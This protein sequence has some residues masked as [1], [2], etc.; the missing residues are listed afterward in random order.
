MKTSEMHQT[1][2]RIISQRLE[3]NAN[4]LEKMFS[5][6]NGKI[7]TRFLIIDDLLPTG[8]A[9][10]IY[11]SFPNKEQ[12]RRLSSFR[13]RKFTYKQL[14]NTSELLKEITFAIQSP[15][16]VARVEKITKIPHQ[17][18]D[19]SLYAG[20]ISMMT[21]GDFLNPHIDNSHDSDRHR[22]RTLNL[23][24]YVTPD[25]KPE[26]GGNLELWDENVREAET[27]PSKFNRFVI[28]ETNRNSWHSV[29]PVTHDGQRC[30]VSNYYF[31]EKSPEGEEYFHVT[32]FS[33]RPEQ[34][35][36]RA[37]ARFD[38]FVRNGLRFIFR[39]GMGKS[40]IYKSNQ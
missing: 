6:R 39:K 7:P 19:S 26:Y 14:D 4:V 13:E 34:V 11:H 22:Y 10:D 8:L 32:S 33:A 1:L 35:F 21:L 17:Q 2:V 29:S 12:M 36:R 28:M 25:W 31:S 40:D 9:R 27:I 23:L 37:L 15:E 3:Q 16:I 24:Y 5:R 30:A 18:P 20:G 38:S